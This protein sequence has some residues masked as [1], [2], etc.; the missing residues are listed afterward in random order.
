M[1]KREELIKSALLE[2]LSG[3]MNIY[4]AD[5]ILVVAD[6]SDEEM[7]DFHEKIKIEIMRL[8]MKKKSK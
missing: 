5:D 1:N 7:Q 2:K 6:I 8:A 4:T 3:G